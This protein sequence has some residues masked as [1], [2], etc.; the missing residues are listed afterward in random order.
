MNIR[1][2]DRKNNEELKVVLI[3]TNSVKLGMFLEDKVKRSYGCVSDTSFEP[4]KRSLREIKDIYQVLPPV[5]ERWYVQI[6]LDILD[7]KDILP[8]IKD[9]QSCIFV[10]RTN[11]YINYKRF[12]EKFENKEE[13]YDFYINYLRLEDFSYLYDVYVPEAYRL[14]KNLYDFVQKGYR[15]DIED[16]LTLFEHLASGGEI[17][18]RKDIIAISGI[19]GLSVDAY[20]FSLMRELS[21]SDKGL[22]LVVKNR[23]REGAE[24][25]GNMG[26]SKFYNYLHSCVFNL[27]RLKTLMMDGTVY[28]EVRK[29]PEFYDDSRIARYSRYI[30]KL[31]EI[32]LSDLIIL[33]SFLESY[34]W[35]SEE[36]FIR[37]IYEYYSDKAKR[38]VERK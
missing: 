19:G 38:L 10:C 25:A 11:K 30:Y 17:K 35:H 32:P 7:A 1:E 13:L 21:G 34:R 5:G 18:S 6:D 36:M 3:Q 27:I 33:N 23:L 14:K 28:K 16:L 15:G 29:L 12:K 8:I 9:S 4:T 31:R 20:S 37:F 26:Y 22:K 24:L 2:L